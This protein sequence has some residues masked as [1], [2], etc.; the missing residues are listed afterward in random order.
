MTYPIVD[1]SDL[2]VNETQVFVVNWAKSSGIEYKKSTFICSGFIDELHVFENI[3]Q[4][5]VK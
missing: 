1:T 5:I 4:I 2:V 3:E